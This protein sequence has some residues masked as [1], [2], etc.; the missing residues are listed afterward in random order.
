MKATS[1]MLV[2]CA[3]GMVAALACTAMY[4]EDMASTGATAVVGAT[5]P[6]PVNNGMAVYDETKDSPWVPGTRTFRKG[7]SSNKK[8][9]WTPA[10]DAVAQNLYFS[11]DR[12][13]AMNGRPLL[14]NVLT[15]TTTIPMPLEDMKL[16]MR[17]YWRVESLGANGE[18]ISKGD[19][20][21]FRFVNKRLKVYLLGGQ[22]NMTGCAPRKDLP[23][24]LEAAQ[25]NVIVYAH[26]GIKVGNYGWDLLRPGLGDGY[27][28]EGAGTFGP[29]LSFG[30]EMAPRP[31]DTAIALIKCAWG[32]TNLKSQWRPPSAGGE[33]G[34]LYT[35]FVKTVH[36]GL[37]TLDPDFVPEIAGMIWMQG[38]ADALDATMYAEYG[39]NLTAFI[40]DIRTEFKSPNLPFV[41]GEIAD[42]PA[43]KPPKWGAEIRA[44]QNKVAKAVPHTAIFSTSDLKLRDPW[45]YD[46]PSMVALG[47]RFAKAMRELDAA[48][49]APAATA[50]TP[51]AAK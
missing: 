9:V 47:E 5:N 17:C 39:A 37:A 10:P 41:I 28:D 49:P 14:R 33:T 22:S 36:E 23:G 42:A 32:A 15:K 13:E 1:N 16:G 46:T 48:S 26:G 29:E 6:K 44:A 12:Q 3:L 51:S 35:E 8:L 40:K 30:H 25:Q 34:K 38:E 18:T 11:R 45:H 7:Y 24:M 19:L 31:D 50:V 20:W 27:G 4:A 21:T 43:Y 2:K